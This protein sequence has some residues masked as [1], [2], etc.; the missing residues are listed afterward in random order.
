MTNFFETIKNA[1]VKLYELVKGSIQDATGGESSIRGCLIYIV[2]MTFTPWAVI[3]LIKLSMVEIP[4]AILTFIGGFAVVK[5]GQRIFEKPE[6][7]TT[8]TT[9]TPTETTSTTTTPVSQ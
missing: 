7:T 9:T 5:A 2:F 4:V 6:I 1:I 3:C 8:T